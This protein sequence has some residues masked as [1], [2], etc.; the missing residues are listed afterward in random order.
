M[1]SSEHVKGKL[2][3]DLVGSR[4]RVPGCLIGFKGSLVS[5]L[6]LEN[7]RQGLYFLDDYTIKA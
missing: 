7:G 3:Q 5:V 2:I 4:I 1:A 6:F